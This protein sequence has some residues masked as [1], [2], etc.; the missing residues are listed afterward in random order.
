MYLFGIKKWYFNWVL[1][2]LAFAVFPPI[3]IYM[4]YRIIKDFSNESNKQAHYNQLEKE[5]LEEEH[6]EELRKI[7]EAIEQNK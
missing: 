1:M 4:F 7:R 6:L 3:V 5:V 2:I